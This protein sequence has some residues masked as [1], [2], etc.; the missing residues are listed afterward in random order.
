MLSKRALFKFRLLP[1][2]K[3]R[4]A[5]GK[6]NLHILARWYEVMRRQTAW[7]HERPLEN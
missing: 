6:S 4:W 3:A 2:F 5:A 1:I 7:G